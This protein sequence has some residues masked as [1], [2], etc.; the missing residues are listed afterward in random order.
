MKAA[1][2]VITLAIVGLVL[3][4]A[5]ILG[6]SGPR[7]APRTASSNTATPASGCTPTA[8]TTQSAAESATPAMP[9]AALRH[10]SNSL[11]VLR[12]AVVPAS[13]GGCA[14]GG[15]TWDPGNIISDSVFY[16]S[17]SMTTAQIRDFITTK[18]TN[19]TTA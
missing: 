16:N 15:T 1:I 2:A 17:S 13:P 6:S 9:A 18:G 14:A 8:P 12:T 3:A 11:T 7:S 10:Q 5:T 4:G 19:C